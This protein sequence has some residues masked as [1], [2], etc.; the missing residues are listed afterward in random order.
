[1]RALP[2]LFLAAC[3]PA[4]APTPTIT[5]AP[6]PPSASTPAPTT[7]ASAAHP[8]PECNAGERAIFSCE[9][10]EKGGA[11]KIAVCG[12]DLDQPSASLT[13]VFGDPSRSEDEVRVPVSADGKLVRY[14]RYTRPRVTMLRLAFTRGADTFEL[15][16]DDVGDLPQPERSTELTLKTAKGERV[17][18]CSGKPKGSLMQLEDHLK[19]QEPWF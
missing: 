8:R 19:L 3:A 7:S 12:A 5:A 9:S 13:L 17:I 15:A 4:A 10:R 2:L 1:M 11:H 16:D 14:A 18:P 6:A